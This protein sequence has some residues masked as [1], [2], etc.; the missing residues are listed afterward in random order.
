MAR[1]VRRRLPVAIA[2]V[3][4]ASGVTAGVLV[5]R[6]VSAVSSFQSVY[7]RMP[8]GVR[9]AVDVWRPAGAAAGARLP[10]VLEADRY[11]R[12]RAYSGGIK[13]NPDYQVAAPWNER[14]YAYV[15]ADVRG[16]GASFGTVKAELGTAMIADI[17]SLADWIAAQRWSDGRVGVT[18]VS[19]SGDAAALSLALRNRHITAAAPVSYDFDPYEDLLRPGGVPIEPLVAR[20]AVVLRILDGADGTTCGTSAETR[21][22]CADDGLTGATPEPVG[23]PRG[24]ALLRG[25]RAQHNGNVNLINFAA[26]GGFRDYSS[27]QQSWAVTSVGAH[28]AAIQAGGVPIL[29]FTGWL[30]AGTANGVLSQFTSLSNTQEDWIGPWSHG[31]NYFADP[32]RPG[33]PLASAEHQQ[34]NEALY[35]FFDRYVKNPGRPSG[36]QVLRYYTLNQGTWRT[37]TTWPLPGTVVRPLY[38]AAGHALSSQP[39]PVG[40]TD[41]LRLHLAVGTG[42]YDRWSTNMTGGPVSYPNRA[43]VDRLLVT[44]TSAPL[45]RAAL[46]TGTARVSLRVTGVQG[47][48]DG[49]LFAYLE[50]VS[51]DGRV[52]YITEGDLALID[53]AE[54]PAQS[55]PS[56][57]QAQDAAQLRPRRRLAVPCG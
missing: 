4:V 16:T 29:T 52:T 47:A 21:E 7:V 17:G 1:G 23:A 8:D 48:S 18:G 46:I 5:T 55:Q 45:R 22:I 54:I 38:L 37:T 43:A 49:A 32:F 57:A 26:A 44:Y 24:A 20:Y 9:L 27:G 35:A 40:G 15:F 3:L 41:L 14:G 10:T 34:L 36:T 19:Y 31:E 28:R 12:A 42:P 51:P 11:W 2:V 13:D 56:L 53:R 30:D 33:R 39:L 25:A 6:A 50:D